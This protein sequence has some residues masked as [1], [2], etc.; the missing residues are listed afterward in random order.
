MR[1]PDNDLS[2]VNFVV[3][4]NDGGLA[5]GEATHA[6]EINESIP[7]EVAANNF[8]G[9]IMRLRA[10][11]ESS[12]PDGVA[13]RWHRNRN[14]T[15]FVVVS[16]SSAFVEVDF[17]PSNDFYDHNDDVPRSIATVGAAFYVDDNNAAMR[18]GQFTGNIPFEGVKRQAEVE[19][20]L[21]FKVSNDQDDSI[22]F[23][24]RESNG[25]VFQAGY[26][27]TPNVIIRR[28]RIGDDWTQ[29]AFRVRANNGPE[30]LAPGS[31][32][33]TWLAPV[34]T[35]VTLFASGDGFIG[36][37][38]GFRPRWLIQ[39]DLPWEDEAQF[40]QMYSLNSGAYQDVTSTSTGIKTRESTGLTQ[41]V[42]TTEFV[43]R[44]G[45]GTWL[46]GVGGQTPES[47]TAF[48]DWPTGQ[49][50]TELEFCNQ[51]YA[52]ELDDGDIIDVQVWRVAPPTAQFIQLQTSRPLETLVATLRITV[53]KV[54][55]GPCDWYDP[56]FPPDWLDS[57]I[58]PDWMDTEGIP[59]WKD[60]AVGAAWLVAG[61]SN[62]FSDQECS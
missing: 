4:F 31:G 20:S 51:L 21:R 40:I 17:D 61:T 34:N 56:E 18:S 2:Q 23:R 16:T 5:D 44:I 55:R 41:G 50:E 43:G 26:D 12:S 13:L 29:A 19:V 9:G 39:S 37:Q 53:A 47:E 14:S 30:N 32:G 24:L 3:K 60:D 48:A 15:G 27:N 28:Q 22:N 58:G 54:A 25:D 38:N 52:D 33:A 35:D 6:G 7:W 46:N 1:V 45:T 36:G 11:V 49:V 59:D 57:A 62:W 8:T 10:T 42:D